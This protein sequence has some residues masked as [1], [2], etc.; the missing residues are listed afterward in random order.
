MQIIIYRSVIARLRHSG[1]NMLHL[2][3]SEAELLE[4]PVSV[5]LETAGR[6]FGMGRTKAFELAKADEFPCRVLRVGQK[7]RVPR[8][9]ILEALGVETSTNASA[10]NA[11]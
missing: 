3:M 7:Y 9:A 4:L 5:D 10:D 6:A 11:A 8:S 2:A 1:G